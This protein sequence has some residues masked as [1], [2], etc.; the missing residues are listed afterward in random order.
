MDPINDVTRLCPCWIIMSDGSQH[1]CEVPIMLAGD[2]ANPTYSFVSGTAQQAVP[3][4]G[5][6]AFE[7]IADPTRRLDVR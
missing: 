6:V 3:W 7:N 2:L 5:I 1:R 4:N